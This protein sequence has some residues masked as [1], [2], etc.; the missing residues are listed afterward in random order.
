MRNQRSINKITDETF[1]NASNAIDDNIRVMRNT[2]TKK[3]DDII[4]TPIAVGIKP[5]KVIFASSTQ[6]LC[7]HELNNTS[8]TKQNV[9][10]GI[11]R[12]PGAKRDYNSYVH[13]IRL[14]IN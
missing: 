8:Q 13:V 10:S 2:L 6:L 4:L 12:I 11:P 3:L 7:L 9:S 14:L 1:I 5:K